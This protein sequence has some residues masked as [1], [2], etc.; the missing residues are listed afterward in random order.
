M[1]LTVTVAK[2][3]DNGSII[4]LRAKLD[5]KK[6]ADIPIQKNEVLSLSPLQNFGLSQIVMSEIE[7]Q[8]RTICKA[9]L[10]MMRDTKNSFIPLSI[11]AYY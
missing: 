4:Q 10:N 1:K 7:D 11:S 5:A 3:D 6:F 8:F 9:I 2:Y